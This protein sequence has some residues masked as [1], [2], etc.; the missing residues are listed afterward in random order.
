M[1][2]PTPLRIVDGQLVWPY[3]ISRLRDDEPSVSIWNNPS[4]AFLAQY[5]MFYPEATTA[6]EINPAAEKVLQVE[7]IEQDGQWQQQWAV[8]ALS[9]AEAADYY[10][11]THP[12]RWLEFGAVVMAL[13]AIKALLNGCIAAGE[14]PLSHGLAVGL[15]KA[16]DGDSRTFINT[17]HQASAAGLIPPELIASMQMLATAHDLPAE[18]IAGLAE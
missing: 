4:D 18:F 11:A 14:T 10:R 7:P 16:A 17:W 2:R 12:P 9:E 6:P 5:G 1:S 15:G 3:S 8:V 13:P